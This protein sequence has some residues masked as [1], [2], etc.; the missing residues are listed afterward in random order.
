MDGVC[1]ICKH[2]EDHINLKKLQVCAAI[3][4]RAIRTW[5]PLG[6]RALFLTDN[7]VAARCLEKERFRTWATNGVT[8]RCSHLRRAAERR[9]PE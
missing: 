9:S 1:G 2:P 3:L 7:L 5:T 8:R 4:Q 6:R